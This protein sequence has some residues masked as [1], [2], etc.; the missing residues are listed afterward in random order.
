MTTPKYKIMTIEKYDKLIT[1]WNMFTCL[2]C[3]DT[4]DPEGDGHWNCSDCDKN[5]CDYCVAEKK[6]M[7]WSKTG[8][9][10]CLKCYDALPNDQKK[11]NPFD[12]DSD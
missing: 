11:I 6:M 1:L 4:V 9:R 8:D 12:E 7:K 2:V 10:Y 3:E 5:V